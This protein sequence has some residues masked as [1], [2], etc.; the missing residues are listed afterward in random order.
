MLI[1]LPVAVVL[2]EIVSLVTAKLVGMGI[3]GHHFSL[4][5]SAM[6]WTLAGFLAIKLTAL[7]ILSGRISHQEIGT[8]LSQ[9]AN[10][11]K[12]HN[13]TR[14]KKTMS[15]LKMKQRIVAVRGMGYRLEAEVSP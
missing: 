11:P 2:S 12:K 1:G 7:L 6:K 14:L 5:W 10:R 3:I 15:G 9:P 4:S 8:L 13:L